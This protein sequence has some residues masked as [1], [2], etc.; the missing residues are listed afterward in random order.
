[1]GSGGCGEVFVVEKVSTKKKMILKAIKI[2]FEGTEQ[3]KNNLKA[4]ESEIKVGISLGSSC[5]FLVQL[6]EFF[7]ANGHCCLIMEFCTGGDL[8][9]MFAEKKRIPQ[10]VLF[11]FI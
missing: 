10:P 7:M 11:F 8:Q 1:L 5:I 4:I 2:G 6:L 9:K 3:F